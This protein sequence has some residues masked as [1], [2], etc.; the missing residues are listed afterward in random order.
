MNNLAFAKSYVPDSQSSA[1]VPGRFKQAADWLRKPYTLVGILV[2][3]AVVLAIVT[4]LRSGEGLLWLLEIKDTKAEELGDLAKVLA[5][6]LALA[7]AIERLLETVFDLFEQATDE[8]A[9][10]SSAGEAGLQWFQ[11]ELDRAWNAADAAAGKLVIAGADEAAILKELEKAEQRILKANSRIV[12]L[13]KDPKYVSTK[14]MLSIWIGLL[15][16][17]IVAVISDLGIFELLQIG[18]PRI[19]DMLV[20]GFV[21]GAG[22]GP[23]HSLV[24]IFQGA[25]NTLENLGE[26]AA[27]KPLKQQIAEL[28][29]K[30]P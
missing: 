18:V 22:S 17:L 3:F 30:I 4:A 27:L 13:I 6:L 11:N 7:L 29:N 12:G 9:K 16:G 1:P 28:Q 19:L 20:T 2:V 14:R 5:P 15:L 8:V 10:L 25:K 24:G 23:M 26:L 21:I